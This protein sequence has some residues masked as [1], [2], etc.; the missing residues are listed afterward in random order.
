MGMLDR[1]IRGEGPLNQGGSLAG[2][3]TLA[4][5]DTH[6]AETRLP[7]VSPENANM[8]ALDNFVWTV[9]PTRRVSQP[10]TDAQLDAIDAEWR[11]RFPGR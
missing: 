7:N 1:L 9:D 6:R 11:A 2:L 8:E 4:L 3:A 10:L 5:A